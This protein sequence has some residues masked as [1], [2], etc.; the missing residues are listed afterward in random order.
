MI[1][2][3]LLDPNALTVNVALFI[4]WAIVIYSISS[5]VGTLAAIFSRLPR[6]RIRRANEMAS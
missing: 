5:V 3:M 4:T 6:A 1:Q 2:E